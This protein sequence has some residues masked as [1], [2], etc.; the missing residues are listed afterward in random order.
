MK[1]A[2]S[3][4]SGRL[5]PRGDLSTNQVDEMHDLLG[6][7]FE[8]VSRNVFQ[9]DLRE[10]N[11]VILLEDRRGKIRGFSTLLYYGTCF[12]GKFVSV[13]Y[14]G[15]TIV[16]R[17][18]WG[19]QTLPRTWIQSVNRLRAQCRTE[20]LFWLLISS[21]YR[22]YRFLPL[23]WKTFYPRY[24]L[25]APPDRQRLLDTLASERF[26]NAYSRKE[27]VVRFD[28][29]QILRRE[30][31]AI[32]AAKRKDPHITFFADRNPGYIRGDELVCLT[33]IAAENLTT[34]GQRMW[35]KSNDGLG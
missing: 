28:Q 26:A 15:D 22:T 21:G 11:W 29:P 8:G 18:H 16:E 13:V 20:R 14:S 30:L 32:P 9:R 24:D 31:L 27:G 5:V 2:T 19:S 4:L 6:G 10:K 35:R 17:A 3:F 23:F 7:Y 1:E 25:L 34:A 12:E 33:E